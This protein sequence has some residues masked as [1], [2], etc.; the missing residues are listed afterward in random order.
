MRE[1]PKLALQVRVSKMLGYGFAFSLVWAAGV[2]SVIA[3]VVGLR[4]RKIIRQSGGEISGIGM[5]WWCILAG[6]AG[7]LTVLP[8]VIWLLIKASKK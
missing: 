1:D 6:A 5:A 7:V 4:A 2:G 3:L 8:Y